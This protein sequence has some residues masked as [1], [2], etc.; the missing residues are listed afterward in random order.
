[1]RKGG[2]ASHSLLSVPLGI[3]VAD[4]PLPWKTESEKSGVGSGFLFPF[5][6]ALAVSVKSVRVI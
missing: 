4:P 3:S 6:L 5:A 1:M 2:D